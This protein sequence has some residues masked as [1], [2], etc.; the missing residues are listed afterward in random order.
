MI[1]GVESGTWLLGEA[2]LLTD[3]KVTVHWEDFDEFAAR[4][5]E[6]DVIKERFVIDGK[7]MTSGGAIPTLDMML[8]IIRRRQGYSMALEVARAFI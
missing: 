8:D 5:P 3:H 6:V 1:V 4:F 7:R 2:G